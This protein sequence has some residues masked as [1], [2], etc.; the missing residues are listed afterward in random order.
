MSRCLIVNADDL[1][2]STGINDGIFEAHRR[3]LVSSATL[4][5]GFAA[6]RDAAARLAEYPSLGVGLH[7]T[8]TGARPT[9]P[10]ER[11]ASLV[12]AAGR[13]PRRPAAIA[14]FDP[15]EARAEIEHQLRLFHALTNRA[16][17]HLDSHHHAHAVPVV[18]DQMVAVARAA[19]LPVRSSTPAIAERLRAEGIPTTDRFVDAFYGD[20]ATLERLLEILRETG[21]GTT[22]VMCHPGRADDELRRESAYAEPREREVELL[23]HPAALALRRELGL[24]L[25]RFGAP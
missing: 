12:D 16:P 10:P 11:V 19:A 3:G 15:A 25:T 21:E 8:L 20:G 22:E 6:A 24:E 1:G 13:L 4:M 14:G 23:C 2:R 17:T 7:V 18:L 5:V 9:L